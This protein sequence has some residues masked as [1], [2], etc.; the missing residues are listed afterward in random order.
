M[1]RAGARSPN[2]HNHATGE[3]SDRLHPYFTVVL[4]VI[5]DIERSAG[6][7]VQ[8]IGEVDRPR[9]KGLGPLGRVVRDLHGNYRTPKK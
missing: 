5:D 8:R 1:P 3:M 2:H 9:G 4:S 7:D 6:K